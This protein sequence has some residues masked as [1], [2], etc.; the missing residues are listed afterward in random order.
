GLSA[1]RKRSDANLQ[2]VKDWVAASDWAAF[3]AEDEATISNTSVCLKI[4]DPEYLALNEE[5]QAASAKKIASLLEKENA[6]YDIG[7]YRDAPAGLRIWCGA[8][9]ETADVKALLPWLD[10]AYAEAKAKA[11]AA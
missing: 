3:L 1:L 10:W 4:I 5:E 8:T 9:V 7:S 11:K 6:A 2:A